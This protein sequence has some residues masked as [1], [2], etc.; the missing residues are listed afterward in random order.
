MDPFLAGPLILI[1]GFLLFLSIIAGV[2]ELVRTRRLP[3]AVVGTGLVSAAVVAVCILWV[4]PG[5]SPAEQA[6]VEQLHRDFAPAIERYRE[7]H[8][9]Y[10]PRSRQPASPRRGPPTA[11]CATEPGA[12][13]TGPPR[14]GS[15]TATT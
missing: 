10:P 11:R 1:F 7:A 3:H 14:T 4:A 5:Y 13:K 8:G 12:S 15:G 2:V 9:Q 6:R